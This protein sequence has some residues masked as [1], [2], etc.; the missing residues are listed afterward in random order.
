MKENDFAALKTGREQ[1]PIKPAASAGYDLKPCPFCGKKARLDMN[2]DHHGEYYFLGCSGNDCI[3]RE[4]LA[5]I[6]VSDMPISEAVEYWN[7][8]S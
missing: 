7:K 6:P 1:G 8:R 3:A 4:I 2:E 5:C